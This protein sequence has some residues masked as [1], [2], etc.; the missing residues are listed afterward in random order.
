MYAQKIHKFFKFGQYN[1]DEILDGEVDERSNSSKKL[2][3]PW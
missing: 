3:H 1:D 2:S